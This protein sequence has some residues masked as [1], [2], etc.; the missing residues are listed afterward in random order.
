MKSYVPFVGGYLSDGF[1][2]IL[3]SSVLIK[4]AVGATGL[5]LL[6]ATVAVPIIKIV[7]LIFGFKLTSAIL[8]P[9][10]DSRISSFIFSVS[11]ALNML[12]ACLLAVAFMYL[13]SVGV[14]MCTCN[15]F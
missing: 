6:L 10:A 2:L 15:I 5:M 13:L 8:E 7:I 9:I 11:K 1:D 12:V 4:N 3:S 14:L